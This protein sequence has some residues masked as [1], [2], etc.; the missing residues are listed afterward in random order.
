MSSEREKIEARKKEIVSGMAAFKRE[1]EELD[2]ALAV[3]GRLNSKPPD[4]PKDPLI[5]PRPEGIPNTFEMVES[6]LEAAE[7]AGKDG[8][9]G[10]ELV[11]GIAEKYWPGLKPKQIL[12][13]I[14][15]FV[16]DRLHK[17]PTGKKFKRKTAQK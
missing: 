13:I 16:P 15:G 10:K 8:L 6:V 12:P 4:K 11:D 14:Y 3:L 5:S 17:T 2:I 9:T 7:M 1:L